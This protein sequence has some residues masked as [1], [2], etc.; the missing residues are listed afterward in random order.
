LALETGQRQG[1]IIKLPWTAYDGQW[2]RLVRD[3]RNGLDTRQGKTK[4]SVEIPATA[5]LRAILD[6]TP[7]NGRTILLNSEGNP[8]TNGA[9]QKAMLDTKARAGV[10]ALTF[11]DLRGTAVTR[12]AEA[13]CTNAEIASITG[14][15]LQS[16]ATILATYLGRTRGLA[17][18]AIRKLEQKRASGEV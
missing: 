8:W 7:R 13:G 10:S 18:S 3:R 5:D 1:D 9:L 2:I 11:H 17:L 15:S 12:L 6:V 16:V 4:A 14:H